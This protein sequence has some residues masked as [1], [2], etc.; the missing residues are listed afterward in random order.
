MD[1]AFPNSPILCPCIP[2]LW[3][4]ECGNVGVKTPGNADDECED[5]QQGVWA[6][7]VS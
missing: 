4:D 2:V 3:Q 1:E 7:T 5:I 6:P